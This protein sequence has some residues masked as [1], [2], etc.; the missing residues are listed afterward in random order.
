LK[1]GG[2]I[3]DSLLLNLY[4]YCHNEPMMYYNPSFFEVGYITKISLMRKALTIFA[5]GDIP[6]KTYS[7]I[8]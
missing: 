7:Y 5:N 6:S 1:R 8:F 3:A 4:T 2:T